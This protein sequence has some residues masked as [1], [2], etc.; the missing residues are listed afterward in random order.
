MRQF[1]SRQ[2]NSTL[3]YKHIWLVPGFKT[4]IRQLERTLK[5][6]S[7]PFLTGSYTF[8]SG[9]VAISSKI[10]CVIYWAARLCFFYTKWYQMILWY[11]R[12]SLHPKQKYPIRSVYPCRFSCVFWRWCGLLVFSS[13]MSALSIGAMQ[14]SAQNSVFNVSARLVK[15]DT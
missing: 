6:K 1:L 4:R 12:K 13:T 8:S 11:S 2:P 14:K 5:K 9:C 15:E 7:V 3:L 10:A